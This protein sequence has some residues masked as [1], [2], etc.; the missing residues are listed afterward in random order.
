ME[1][2]DFEFEDF[3]FESESGTLCKNKR[4]IRIPHQTAL[5]L[6]MLLARPGSLVTRDELQ[7]V[8][9]PGGEHLD[10]QRGVNKAVNRLREALRDDPKSP[11]F[12]ETIPKRGYRFIA[13]VR[14][15][16]SPQFEQPFQVNPA[17]TDQPDTLAIGGD[18]ELQLEPHSSHLT[19]P[20]PQGRP[21][22]S[23]GALTLAANLKPAEA[24]ATSARLR[25]YAG[26]VLVLFLLLAATGTR[27]ALHRRQPPS[28]PHRTMIGIAPFQSDSPGSASV[29]EDFR[30]DIASELAQLPGVAVSVPQAA[31]GPASDA[32]IPALARNPSLDVFLLGSI[33]H[34][35]DQYLLR[36]ELL[37]NGDA[38]YLAGF[39]YTGSRSEITAIGKRV[40]RDLFDYLK[41]GSEAPQS[42][43]PQI[44]NGGTEDSTA[45]ADYLEAESNIDDES[46]D[47]LSRAVDELNAALKRDPKFALAYVGLSKAYNSLSDSSDDPNPLLDLA[48]QAATQAV[49]LNPRLASA[50]AALGIALFF[51]DWDASRAES[52]LA[53]A[54]Q[55]EPGRALYHNQLAVV[56][57]DEGRFDRSLEQVQ[58]AHDSDHNW[59]GAYETESYLQG[60]ARRYPQ[61]IQAAETYVSLRPNWPPARDTLA[62]ALFTAGRYAGAITQWE[63]MA[64]ME[65]DAKRSALE[66]QAEAA[67]HQQGIRGYA[68]VHLAAALAQQQSGSHPN[69][70]VLAEWYAYAGEKDQAIQAL[71][72]I[73]A[74]HSPLALELAIDPMY[75]SLHNDPRYLALLARVGLSLPSTHSL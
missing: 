26:I 61:M 41:A 36:L 38:N 67:F 33:A 28:G 60:A 44:A 10:Y 18:A 70:F 2:P 47:A 48:K 57:A 31:A 37:R 8:L 11:R 54:I 63:L 59:D 74:S 7:R 27:F 34:S 19:V 72:K 49:N 51:R 22:R 71:E 14:R 40:Q 12:L 53:Y 68:R 56:L 16:E 69:D 55:L 23:L 21:V 17:P 62:W 32:G 43:T 35:G 58:L 73:V 46:P 42:V 39:Q 64:S 52:E 20:S 75:E 5:L 65:N 4:R 1:R 13:P 15:L 66:H 9:W 45:F 24:R 25:L 6:K 50:H 29:A 30:L 3:T